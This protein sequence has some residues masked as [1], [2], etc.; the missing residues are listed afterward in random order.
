MYHC[1]L[2]TNLTNLSNVCSC[3]GYTFVSLLVRRQANTPRKLYTLHVHFFGASDHKEQCSQKS[4]C[5][6]FLH[7]FCIGNRV[8]M[9]A[10]R[11]RMKTKKLRESTTL[12]VHFLSSKDSCTLSFAR[13]WVP[14]VACD[15]CTQA[16]GGLL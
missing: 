7:F 10:S 4:I 13:G 8:T 6:T 14:F 16:G 15:G 1:L 2:W 9:L 12:A 5:L 11:S 3:T